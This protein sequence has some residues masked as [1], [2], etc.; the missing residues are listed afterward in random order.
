MPDAH[1]CGCLR[2]TKITR[3]ASDVAA[4]IELFGSF[5]RVVMHDDAYIGER[6]D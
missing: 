4:Y 1:I 5:T 6:S 2:R 3:K